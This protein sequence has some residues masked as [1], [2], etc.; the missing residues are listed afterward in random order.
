MNIS[1]KLDIL[2]L[3]VLSNTNYTLFYADYTL[4]LRAF[5]TNNEISY[6]VMKLFRVILNKMIGLVKLLSSESAKR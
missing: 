6:F 4:V 5:W 3:I 1:C 2:D